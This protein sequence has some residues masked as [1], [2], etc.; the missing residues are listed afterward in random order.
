MWGIVEPAGADRPRGPNRRFRR[1]QRRTPRQDESL[2]AQPR[3]FT[4]KAGNEDQLQGSD[5]AY[6]TAWT[7]RTLALCSPLGSISAFTLLLTGS[8]L[9]STRLSSI[10][11]DLKPFQYSKM[12]AALSPFGMAFAGA[13]GG[14]VSNSIVSVWARSLGGLISPPQADTFP[15]PTPLATGLIQLPA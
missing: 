13:V 10:L 8:A 2:L 1:N 3:P 12:A 4:Y 15:R 9:L 6:H 7:W 11:V 14:V 5:I